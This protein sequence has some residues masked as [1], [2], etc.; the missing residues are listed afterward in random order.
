[1]VPL[2]MECAGWVAG[3]TRRGHI[4]VILSGVPLEEVSKGLY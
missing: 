4:S 2:R 3:F 1:M